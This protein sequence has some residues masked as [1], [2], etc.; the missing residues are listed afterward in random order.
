MFKNQA[1]T[2]LIREAINLSNQYGLSLGA[3][4]LIFLDLH[5]TETMDAVV[6]SIIDAYDS[7]SCR[8]T[9]SLASRG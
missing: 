2:A 1:T 3:V 4:T 6:V 5:I 9:S 7:G 8:A